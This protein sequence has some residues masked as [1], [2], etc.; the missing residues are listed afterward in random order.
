MSDSKPGFFKRLLGS[1]MGGEQEPTAPEPETKAPAGKQGSGKQT[2]AK[3]TTAKKTASG[4][5]SQKSPA[6]TKASKSSK[7]SKSSAGTKSAGGAGTAAKKTSSASKTASKPKS[8][9]GSGKTGAGGGTKSAAKS[10][11]KSAAKTE[12]RAEPAQKPETQKTGAKRQRTQ[13]KSGAKKTAGGESSDDPDP[14]VAAEPAAPGEGIAFPAAAAEEPPAA[15]AA[16]A[17]KA[18]AP[19]QGKAGWFARLREGLSKTSDALTDNITG[20]FTKRRLD[21]ATLQELEDAL[22][23]ADLGVDMAM[24]ITEAVARGRYNKE[25]APEE[26]RAVLGAEVAAVLEPTAQPLLLDE[27]KK[28][29][30]LLVVGV[31]GTGKTT[32]IGKLAHQ[33]AQDGRKTVMA[34]GDTF[35]AAAIDQ[36]KIWGERTGADV[37][38]REVGADAAG[39]AYD[40]LAHA[41]ETGADALMIDTAGR[42]Q[43]K[44]DLMDELAKI[45]RVVKKLDETAPHSVLLVL[46]ATTGQNA[47]RQVEVFQEIAGV[48]GLIMTKLDGTARGG[49]LVAIAKKFGL[50]VHAVGVG[51]SV[52]DLQPFDAHEF[53]SLIAG[54]QEKVDA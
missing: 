28:P 22:I 20:I 45:V 6:G 7:S 25:I 2:T 33:F 24:Q 39:L 47:M 34:A 40:A 17:R 21:E 12:G 23:Q 5:K 36:L 1:L 49:I 42:L 9:S 27:T 18:E 51:E 10:A 15:A 41:R 8:S 26:V 13:Q 11:T 19:A 54:A 50:P 29:H 14:G 48:T 53:A 52:D 16:P 32:T 3:K 46:D 38:A 37:V 31:N 4:T 43:N 35:R 30:V 44:K